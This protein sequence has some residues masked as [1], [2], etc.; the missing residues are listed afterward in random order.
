MVDEMVEHYAKNENRRYY[1]II[2]EI[3]QEFK[4]RVNACRDADD[5]ALTEKEDIQRRWQ[6]NFEIVI[7]GNTYDA[8]SMTF[9]TAGNDDIQP[10]YE[11]VTHVIKCLKNTRRQEHIR[12]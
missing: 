1:K 5:K 9:F 3:A 10:S 6:E 11:E 8:D 12:Y 7:T 4:A 2:Q